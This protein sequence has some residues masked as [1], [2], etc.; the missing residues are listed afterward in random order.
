AAPPRCLAMPRSRPTR[1]RARPPPLTCETIL[2]WADEHKARTGNYPT[3]HSGRV[4]GALSE[5][6]VAVDMALRVGCRGLPGGTSLA[7]LLADPRGSRHKHRLLALTEQ[8]IV[9]LA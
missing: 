3:L 7:Q 8:V 9:A 6:W 1:L 4:V 2:R 5:S